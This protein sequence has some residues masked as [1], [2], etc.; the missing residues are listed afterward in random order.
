MAKV[1]WTTP[2]VRDLELAFDY[3]AEQSG[4]A[5]VAERLCLDIFEAPFER[6]EKWPD[7]GAMVEPLRHISAR[8]IYRHSYRII[9]VHRQGACYVIVCIHSS[10]ELMQLL[11]PI[12]WES[13][14]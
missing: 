4:S 11:D 12:R 1:I 13:L 3:L 9:Y 10:R 6:L 5:D 14:P 7:S 2:A 8:E